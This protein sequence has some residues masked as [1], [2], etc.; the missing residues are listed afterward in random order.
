MPYQKSASKFFEMFARLEYEMC[1]KGIARI[2]ERNLLISADWN[3]LFKNT[4]DANAEQVI[5]FI[6]QFSDIAINDHPQQLF[7]NEGV[8]EFEWKLPESDLIN[9]HNFSRLSKKDQFNRI[10][11]ALRRVRNNLFHGSK[12][13]DPSQ[14]TN[15]RL[16]QCFPILE[17]L[18]TLVNNAKYKQPRKILDQK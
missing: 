5:A 8:N 17:E 6:E 7:F 14:W 3:H 18:F 16:D 4:S 2:D 13:K 12:M 1:L 9:F 15:E 11:L 10:T